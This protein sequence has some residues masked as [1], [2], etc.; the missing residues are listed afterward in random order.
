M[1][2]GVRYPDEKCRGS[3]KGGEKSRYRRV[4]KVVKRKVGECKPKGRILFDVDI[5]SKERGT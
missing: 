5:E 3:E 1:G 2:E 4:R